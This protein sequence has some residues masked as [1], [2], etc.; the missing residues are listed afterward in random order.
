MYQL[1]SEP[2][3]IGQTLDKGFS[4]FK[5]SFTRV[6]GISLIGSFGAVPFNLVSAQIQDDP[7]PGAIGA[8]LIVMVL[9]LIGGVIIIA[10]L[11]ARIGSIATG[12]PIS[13][14][15]SLITGVRRLPAMLGTFVIAGVGIVVGT[16]LLIIPGLFLMVAWA[17]CVYAVALDNK[18]PIEGISASM[19]LVRGR[20][21]RT[22]G[23]ITL[24]GIIVFCAYTI[25]GLILGIAVVVNPD[26]A[27]NDPTP[28]L[29]L[30]DTVISPAFNAVLTPLSYALF[31][32]VYFDLKLRREGTDLAERID[33]ATE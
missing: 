27:L 19:D 11:L 17:F 22:A 2:M 28:L 14:K 25:I 29:M 5:A 24:I 18:G 26:A 3:S 13:F 12:N 23:I 10:A 20:W 9:T 7:S 8:F 16:I 32:V 4:L 6:I 1:A 21:W 15:E 30:V 31:M 33:A